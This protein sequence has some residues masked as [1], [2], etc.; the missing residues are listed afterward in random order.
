MLAVGIV[1]A[2]LLAG[3]GAE[4]GAGVP[5]GRAGVSAGA[6]VARPDPAPAPAATASSAARAPSVPG[7]NLPAS[8]LAPGPAERV[9]PASAALPAPTEGVA[10]TAPP[11]VGCGEIGGLPGCVVFNSVSGSDASG[12]LVWLGTDPLA[13]TVSTVEGQVQGAVK[14]PCNRGSGPAMLDGQTLTFD[15]SRFGSTAMGCLG[16]A[17]GYEAWAFAM[18]SE[19]VHYTYDGTT[20]TWTDARGTVVFRR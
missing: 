12:P 6:D 7:P 3:C 1:A 11:S 13:F 4:L 18:V 9:A 19:P 20:L 10:P 16:A 15:R 17:A 14:T 5:T 8:T 2:G